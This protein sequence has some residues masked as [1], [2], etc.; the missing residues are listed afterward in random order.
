MLR[1]TICGVSIH[2]Y[3]CYN[4]GNYKT[5]DSVFQNTEGGVQSSVERV[6]KHLFFTV[7]KFKCGGCNATYVGQTGRH[8]HI[9][10]HEHL[11]VSSITGNQIKTSSSIYEHIQQTGHWAD[12]TCFS[13]IC[14]ASN[15][16]DLPILERFYIK[17]LKPDLNCQIENFAFYLICL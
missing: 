12:N 11:G 4:T 16:C 8:L 1:Y 10:I 7:Y 6:S 14:H 3:K 13:T 2:H 9:R 15:K 5:P 17:K